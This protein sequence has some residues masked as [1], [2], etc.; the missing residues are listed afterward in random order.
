MLR[1]HLPCRTTFYFIFLNRT[2]ALVARSDKLKSK[3]SGVSLVTE[4]AHKTFLSI[5]PTEGRQYV[6]YKCNY[7]ISSIRCLGINHQIVCCVPGV[8]RSRGINLKV[9]F[10]RRLEPITS[11]TPGVKMSRGVWSRKDGI[12]V[13][14]IGFVLFSRHLVSV[15]TLCVMC[16]HTFRN[17]NH[18]IRP[19][20]K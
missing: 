6:G 17:W 20:I 11:T 12:L 2:W 14:G 1:D 13:N 8:K 9:E 19:C 3:Y 18:Q 10:C 7:R 16:N 15:W 4:I 5:I